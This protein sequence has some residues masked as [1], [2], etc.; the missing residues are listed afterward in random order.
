MKIAILGNGAWGSALD[1]LARRRNH[2]S[3]MWGPPFSDRPS[4]VLEETLLGAQMV[5]LAIPSHV[6]REVCQ[7]ATPFFP[8]EVP[9]V[10]VA[11]G[12]EQDT[13]LCMS[14]VIFEEVRSEQIAAL[15]GPSFASEV[16]KGLPTAVVC[17]S[18]N[19]ELA[20]KI[21]AAL[22]GEDFRIYTTR[23]IRGVE[24]G[25]ALKNVIAIAAGACAGLGLGE[26]ARA[27]LI[28]R[29]LAEL[30]RVGMALGGETQTFF[31]LSGAGDLLLT[32]SSSQSRNFQ[33]G[34]LLGE[35]QPLE[36]ILKNLQGTAEGIKTSK[37]V[38]QILQAQKID[39]PISE[40]VYQ[41]VHEGK[42]ARAALKS[43]MAREPKAEEVLPA[44]GRRSPRG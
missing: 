31:G 4:R 44:S 15:S 42:P 7:S 10:S 8:K 24:L 2:E 12:I 29:A 14:Q 34:Q 5:I 33:V 16:K 40:E 19:E 9:L 20:E 17:A 1:A 39:A 32:C 6:M 26:N 13:D 38:H 3:R 25:G 11:K 36:T 43:L 18:R 23:D 28:T 22:N 41:M 30:A 35:G 37:S 27:A 21:Q